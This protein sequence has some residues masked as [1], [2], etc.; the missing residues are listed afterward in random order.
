VGLF[1]TR[2]LYPGADTN[3]KRALSQADLD[4]P[5]VRKLRDAA[6]VAKLKADVPGWKES[7]WAHVSIPSKKVAIVVISSNLTTKTQGFR[8]AWAKYGWQCFCIPKAAA[9]KATVE[10]LAGD[11][12][13]AIGEIAK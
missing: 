8:D 12:L 7:A 2:D 5:V 10:A 1:V 9:G 6:K 11:L 3:T 4:A 13:S